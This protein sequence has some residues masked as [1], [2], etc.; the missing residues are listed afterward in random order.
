MVE[1][2]ASDAG[3]VLADWSAGG[4]GAEP[5]FS[6]PQLRPSTSDHQQESA[7]RELVYRL[8]PDRAAEFSFSVSARLLDSAGRDL[9]TVRSRRDLLTVRAIVICSSVHG[10][11][12]VATCSRQE[13]D[14]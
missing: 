10:E 3:S 13:R 7:V 14:A 6:Y 5:D 8:I 9:F 11:A 1:A 4:G 2:L 12:E